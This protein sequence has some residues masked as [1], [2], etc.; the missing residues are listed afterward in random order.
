MLIG[1]AFLEKVICDPV[2]YNSIV[3]ENTLNRNGFTVDLLPDTTPMKPVD[4]DKNGHCRLLPAKQSV[5]PPHPHAYA[6]QV[7]GWVVSENGQ[8]LEKDIT[9]HLLPTDEI[10]D[11]MTAAL[12]GI[13]WKHETSGID[14]AGSKILTDRESYGMLSNTYTSLKNGLV[15]DA[16][17]KSATGWITVTLPALEPIAKAVAEHV[18]AA[19]AAERYVSEQI[20][21]KAAD[22]DALLAIDL[23][24]EFDQALALL[25][26]EDQA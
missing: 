18:R 3:F 2:P 24:H 10:R 23:Q 1:I 16:Q 4:L 21:T 25:S 7:N 6:P 11:N 17:W 9:W 15:P 19:F 8:Y 26:V 12:S 14:L 5:N 13:R 22:A 20:I